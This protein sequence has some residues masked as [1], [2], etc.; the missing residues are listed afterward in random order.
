VTEL[1]PSILAA[2]FSR[3][4]EE[5]KTVERYAGR[6]HVDVM[7]GHFVPNLSMGPATV[8]DIRPITA[9]PIE[10]H[11]MVEDPAA[12]VEPFAKAGANRLTFHV[13]ATGD[14]TATVER[15]HQVECAAGIAIKPATSWAAVEPLLDVVDLVI[16]M[17]VEPGFGGQEFLRDMLAKIKEGRERVMKLGR[18]VDIEVD[19]GIDL[20][21]APRAKQAGA[22]VFVAGSSI[23][24][25]PN[26]GEAAANLARAI[27]GDIF[28]NK[29]SR[30]ADEPQSPRR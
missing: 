8:E 25:S 22:N 15:I 4:G 29:S 19:G 28:F 27:N 5:I 20:E 13:E 9:L 6:I 12:F 17:T 1:A 10:V 3:L 30:G 18:A 2:N 26:P 14:P 16:V 23:F 21:T 24:D 7:D 11:L